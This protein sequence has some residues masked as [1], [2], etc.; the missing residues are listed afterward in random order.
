MV[1]GY[2][3]RLLEVDLSRE[4]VGVRELD[5]ETL[6]G[7]VGGRGLAAYLLVR[8]LGEKWESVDPL[9][10]DNVLLFLTG[11]LTGY[12]PGVKLAVSGKSPQS[13]GIVG[14]VLSSELAIELRAAG[15]DGLVVRGRARD[16][17]YI[18]VEG[19]RAEIRGAEH[20]W[21]LGGR[22][23]FERLMREVWSDL[24]RRH[25]AREGLTKEPSFVYIGPAG[26]RMVRTAAV[27]AKLTHAAGYGGYG[28]VMGSKRLKAVV[29]KG[30][31][32]MPPARHPEWVKLLVRE[33]WR[34]LS[35]RTT[36]RQWGTGS[37]GFATAAVTSSEPVRNWQEEWHENRAMGQ[38]NFEAHWVKRFWADYGCPSACMKISYLRR[39]SEEG[40]ITDTPDYEM[41]AYLGPNLGVFEPRGCV[42]LSYLADEL[43]LCGIQT[44]NLLGLVAELYE[45]GVLSREELGGLEPKWGD[46]RAFARLMEMIAKREGLGDAM[47]EGSL[48]FALRVSRDKGVDATRFV[49]HSKGIAIGAHGVRSGKDYL[50]PFSYAVST[51]GGD[52]TSAPRKPYTLPWGELWMTFPDS[53]VICAFNAIDELMFQFLEAVTGFGITR[54][55]WMSVHGKRILALQ[56]IALLLGGPDVH[57]EPLRDDDL[58]PRFYEPLP[59]GPFAGKAADRSE[60]E[61]DRAEYFAF[62]GW[63]ERGVPREETLEE[64]GLSFAV[65]LV[66]KIKSRVKAG[67]N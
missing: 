35:A 46:Y 42:H 22:E 17:V 15:Y 24:K 47:A 10:E 39:G 23:T 52:H 38:Q 27:M 5:E 55:A 60:V 61:K 30:F 36:F 63:D 51:Q 6:R 29:A 3:G 56:R 16:P 1:Y 66:K 31:G 25:L 45:R 4:K 53:A 65:G 18:Y 59:S 48:R 43:G 13:N 12:Y 21:G 64:L 19:E 44:G 50:P 62:M 2:H 26:E 32:P 11:P 7:Y 67:E 28:A 58:P 33:A 20:L 49:V 54:D 57:W 37:G 8:E 40:S 14:S 41:Q 34:K 9:G